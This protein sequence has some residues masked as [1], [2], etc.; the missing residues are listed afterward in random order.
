MLNGAAVSVPAFLGGNLLPVTLGNVLGGGLA[1]DEW[2]K[3]GSAP[4]LPSPPLPLA[5]PRP[6][7][8]LAFGYWY[9]YGTNSAAA[10][11]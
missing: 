3:G 1:R 8:L 6:L 9:A 10:S 7:Q 11:H 5:H 2:G 4:P